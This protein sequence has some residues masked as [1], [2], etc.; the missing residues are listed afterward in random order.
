M[1]GAKAHH[2]KEQGEREGHTVQYSGSSGSNISCANSY[3][4][5]ARSISPVALLQLDI[6]GSISMRLV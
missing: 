2:K 4:E 3:A 5:T 1:S 6:I